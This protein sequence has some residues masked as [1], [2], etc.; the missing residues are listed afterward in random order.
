LV[1][2]AASLAVSSPSAFSW[3]VSSHISPRFPGLGLVPPQRFHAL[4]VLIRS[5]PAGLVSCRIRPWGFPSGPIST[6]RAVQPLGCHYPLVVGAKPPL[7]GLDPCKRPSPPGSITRTRRTATLVGFSSLGISPSHAGVGFTNLPLWSF[8]P[9][10]KRSGPCS[11]EACR[12]KR[13][14]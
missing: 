5:P 1:C 2:P 9:R 14:A 7:Q 13:L 4:E 11:T 12:R 10:A 8:W 6:C 3:K